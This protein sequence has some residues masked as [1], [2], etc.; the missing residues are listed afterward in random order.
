MFV[1][2]RTRFPWPPDLDLTF[3]GWSRIRNRQ[4]RRDGRSH[5]V[6]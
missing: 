4:R 1:I 6:P 3:G 2:V 5:L